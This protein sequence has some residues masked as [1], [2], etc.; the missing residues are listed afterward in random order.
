MPRAK[1]N[2]VDPQPDG[3]I[4]VHTTAAPADG[5]ANAAVIKLLARHFDVP[6]STIR[7]VRGTTSRDKVIEF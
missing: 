5:D 6:K 7:I 2:K 3:T 1:L 4:R